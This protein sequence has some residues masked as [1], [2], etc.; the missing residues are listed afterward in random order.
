M[1]PP[2]TGPLS[3]EKLALLR[4][5]VSRE[6]RAVHTGAAG[7]E[8]IPRRDPDRPA[9]LSPAQRRLWFF[10]QLTGPG[11]VYNIAA[12]VV[13][14]GPLDRRALATAL[15]WT[16]GRHETLRTRFALVAGQPVQ[17]VMPAG[18]EVLTETD[19]SGLPAPERN[20]RAEA[21]T[22]AEARRGFDLATGPPLR[23]HLL[24]LS[25]REH[26]LIVVVHHIAAD[27]WSIGLLLREVATGYRR[28]L[29]GDA[30]PP[31]EPSV[32][33]TD[34][35]AWQV[36]RVDAG[37]LDDALAAWHA[38]LADAPGLVDLPTD[39]PRSTRHGFAGGRLA[40]ELPQP[41]CETLRRL[42]RAEDATLFMTLLAGLAA[43]LYRYTL[44]SDLVVGAPVANRGRPELD[45]L[46]GC[47]V[48]LLPLRMR[49]RG[50]MS[51]R[52]L[53]RQARDVTLD[54][55]ARQDVP[56]DAIVERVRPHREAS[57]QAPLCNVALALQGA[58]HAGHDMPGLDVGIEPLDT[59][60][61]RFDL[62]I[63]LD[64]TTDP[65]RGLVDFSA[66]LFDAQ[67]VRG[68]LG[69][70]RTLLAAAAAD[71]D[72][73]VD[74]LDLL[75]ADEHAGILARATAVEPVV[76]AA[77][78]LPAAFAGQAA[79]TPDAV[80]ATCGGEHL[81]YAQLDRRANQLAH[82]L[83][84]RGAGPE[85]P[86]AIAV[87]PS[88]DLL[89]AILGI[90]RSGAAYVP[91]DPHHP[92]ARRARIV[93]E[94]GARVLV[95]EGDLAAGMPDPPGGVLLLD[96][97][98]AALAARPDG[99]P[100]TP[101]PTPDSLAYV[102]HTSGSTG[103]PKGALLTHGCVLRLVAAAQR[104]YGFTAEDTWSMVHSAA[105]DV[106]VWEMWGAW[107]HGGRVLVVP[108]WQRR[109]P[110]ALLDLLAAERVSVLSQTPTAFRQVVEE[111]D[112]RGGAD[113]AVRYV[114]LA[115]EALEPGMLRS[116][117]ARRG[118][119][120]P[121]VV[122]MY[123][124]TETTVH[125]T[126]HRVTEADAGRSASVI[127]RPLA[128]VRIHLLDRWMR[129]VPDG[130]VGEMYLGGGG[131]A[132][133]YLRRGGLTAERFLPDPFADAPGAR[134]Y[135]S[136]DLARRRRS[137]RLEYVG[138]G[139]QQIKIR[140]HRVEPGEIEAVLSRHPAVA[141]VAV[142][143]V[144][145][146]A[147]RDRLTGYLVLR[148]PRPPVA[149]L[150][151][152]LRADL[153]EHMVPD[154]FVVLDAL[155][156]TANGKLDRRALPRPESDGAAGEEAA[157]APTRPVELALAEIW[158]EALGVSRV[159]LQDSFFDLGGHSLLAV[160]VVQQVRDRLGVDLPV[161]ALLASPT[162]GELAA[163]LERGVP[164]GP[165]DPCGTGP[166]QPAE[167]GMPARSGQPA[168]DAAPGAADD[169]IPALGR[170]GLDADHVAQLSDQL[171]AQ[172]IAELL[173][174]RPR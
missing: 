28:A 73:A 86:V 121:R 19:L 132:R 36:D 167:P 6:T 136:G 70:Y 88:L 66:E 78:S 97:D 29:A 75:T 113:L 30:E 68:L 118:D 138:R 154:A 22:R 81:T 151:R 164:P 123:G 8:P 4:H 134:L 120:R 174:G 162:L 108:Y 12:Q 63:Q 139:D 141:H 53:L 103:P 158:A 64:E 15:G 146:T 105:F 80:A 71:P 1:T 47:L 106:S 135:R 160:R 58:P 27:G 100:E 114:V 111:D 65:V 3:A 94:S 126:W 87:E 102:I 109:S 117:F 104:R 129:P 39:R 168:A 147:G 122:N 48:N 125:S 140:G 11:P 2:T 16:V 152:R 43:V 26:R 157:Q 77:R 54:G 166:D 60:T 10:D 161:G 24:T 72:T 50:D 49:V 119:D 149:E 89:V 31:G 127:G 93:A 91:L 74:A 85:V 171:S 56:F 92:A 153:P 9:P 69:S 169:P 142:A 83:R 156:V 101:G 21:L 110:H 131:L 17:H 95:T 35:A 67:T 98:R 44:Q 128:D 7:F 150:R 37:R 170:H 159:G 46:V 45:G 173:K 99:A 33:Y 82:A 133:G 84:E 116:W 41:L 144:P 130:A 51:F 14:R 42:S 148:G 76:P 38:R 18:V 79:A 115:G 55:L 172:D 57:G 163:L 40:W 137:G 61:S 34:V 155:P 112:R 20:R 52:D 5:L 96:A 13:L 62:N 124:I 32:R 23:A 90:L 145:D 59:G 107:L 165:P 143:Y 25:E